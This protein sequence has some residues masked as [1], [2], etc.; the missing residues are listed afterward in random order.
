MVR[1][2]QTSSQ[3]FNLWE[4]PIDITVGRVNV[5]FI[6]ILSRLYRTPKTFNNLFRFVFRVFHCQKTYLYEDSHVLHNS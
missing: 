6:K 4:C 3:D 2:F 1:R 5:M